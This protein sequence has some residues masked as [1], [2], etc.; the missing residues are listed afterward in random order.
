MNKIP[1][2]LDECIQA[3]YQKSCDK[4][5]QEIVERPEED[6]IEF[7]HTLGRWMRNEWKL[8]E[9]GPLK[10]YFATLGIWHPD[11]MSGIILDS[12]CRYLKGKPIDL[13]GQV[14][15]YLDYWKKNNLE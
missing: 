2:N 9:D 14:K 11:D 3:L 10:D 4:D 13:E 5:R 12:F 8:W 6:M 7:H 1:V 15:Q